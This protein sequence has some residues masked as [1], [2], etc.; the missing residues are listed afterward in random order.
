[1]FLARFSF[2]GPWSTR[3][4]I[5][6]PVV[7]AL[8]AAIASLPDKTPWQEIHARV[9]YPQMECTMKNLKKLVLA[10]GAG[11][12]LAAMTVLTGCEMM[13]HRSGDRTAGRT[14]DDKIITER[15]EDKLEA[16]PVYKISDIDVKTF[17]GVVQLSGFV[18]T[19]EQKQRAGELAQ[20]VQGVTRVVNNITLKPATLSP[21][22]S[23]RE[24]ERP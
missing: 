20:S 5:W 19:D 23:S 22:G 11:V 1:L 14:L 21:T 24:T 13:G 10:G 16:E 4:F 7:R 2:F 12:A 3:I 8:D 17:G 15:V 9:V 6:E 18:N